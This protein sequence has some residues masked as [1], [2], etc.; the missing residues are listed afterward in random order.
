ME[1]FKDYTIDRMENKG[2]VLIPKREFNPEI[3]SFS[4]LLLDLIDFKDRVRPLANDVA[5]HDAAYIFQRRNVT[6]LE[7]TMQEFKEGITEGA[8]SQATDA[9]AQSV[10]EAGYSSLEIAAE[11]GTE[12]PEAAEPD[13]EAAAQQEETADEQE[14]DNDSQKKE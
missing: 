10:E 2:Y 6:E 4:N 12:E 7:S 14:Q 11:S 1:L 5:K 3:S 8:A 9:A 13:L